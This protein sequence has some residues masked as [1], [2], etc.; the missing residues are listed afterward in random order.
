[1][2][3]VLSH[4]ILGRFALQQKLTKHQL[5]LF[6]EPSGRQERATRGQKTGG[7]QLHQE[8][9]REGRTQALAAEPIL[10]PEKGFSENSQTKLVWF[11]VDCPS[12]GPPLRQHLL[13]DFL[14][15]P[16]GEWI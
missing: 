4:Y 1:M 11:P 10:G 15:G 7:P 16:R 2:A 3:A 8:N 13:A 6:A 14:Q 5:C 9:R 12:E